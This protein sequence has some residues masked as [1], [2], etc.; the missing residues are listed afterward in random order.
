[1]R[2]PRCGIRYVVPSR[3][4]LVQRYRGEATPG[5]RGR[6]WSLDS[7]VLDSFAKTS[8]DA[9]TAPRPPSEND[10]PSREGACQADPGEMSESA[11][12][13]APRRG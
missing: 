12:A 11:D 3:R 13:D 8:E 10:V 2:S 4:A 5:C 6:A 7:L 9:P 1:M